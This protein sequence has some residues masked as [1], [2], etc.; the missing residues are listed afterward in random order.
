MT[1]HKPHI[2]KKWLRIFDDIER[3]GLSTVDYCK[4]N[5]ISVKTLYTWRSKLR[6]AK[7]SSTNDH[8]HF[9]EV[10][11]KDLFSKPLSPSKPADSINIF[12]NDKIR[13]SVYEDFN[14][15]LLLKTIKVIN[16]AIC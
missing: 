11:L 6:K 7:L 13:I 5:N 16:N 12:I 9:Q 3:S 4:Q 2:V 10:K 15:S 8:H 14:E 1:K